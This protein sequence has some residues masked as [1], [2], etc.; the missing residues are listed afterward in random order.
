MIFSD[1]LLAALTDTLSEHPEVINDRGSELYEKRNQQNVDGRSF[2]PHIVL[3]FF[4]K[5]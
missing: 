1:I 5:P 3:F 4:V 2:Y